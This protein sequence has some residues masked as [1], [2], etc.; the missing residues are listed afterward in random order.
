MKR[1]LTIVT[2][3]VLAAVFAVSANAQG[4]GNAFGVNKLKCFD[5]ATDGSG[6]Y[7]GTCTLSSKGAKNSAVLKTNGGDPQGEYAGVYSDNKFIYGRP[8]SGVS[9]LRFNYS[10]TAPGAGA[11]RFSIPIDT[12]G[13]GDTDVWG[14]LSAFYCND[15]SGNVDASA[16]GCTF[17]SSVGGPYVG[18]NNFVAAFPNAKVATDEYVFIVAD[19]PGLWTI[20]NVNFGGPGNN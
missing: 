2:A 7:G 17:Y 12:D 11:P 3:I 16:P 10:G 14:Y 15:G 5:G 4:N 20:S 13:D 6:I 8:L 1:I 18:L 19:E 9:A